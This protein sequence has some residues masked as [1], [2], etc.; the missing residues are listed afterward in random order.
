MSSEETK[1]F[2]RPASGL[3]RE[4]SITNAIFYNMLSSLGLSCVIVFTYVVQFPLLNIAGIPLYSLGII[5]TAVICMIFGLCFIP[6]VAAMPRSG[7]DYIFTSRI[8]HPY[9]GF[10]ETW[11]WIWA[12]FTFVALSTWVPL[13]AIRINLFSGVVLPNATQWLSWAE[14]I[15][16]PS[17]VLIF[18][19]ILTIIL[20]LVC[21]LPTRLYAKTLTI[22]GAI[23]FICLLIVVFLTIGAS[24]SAFEE[25]F[26]AAM[27][28]K[29]QE[30][31]N[32]AIERG[33][34][35][36]GEFDWASFGMLFTFALWALLGFNLSAYL[37]GEL[38][39]D[40]VRN[41]LLAMLGIFG[42]IFS[43]AIYYLPF[44]TTF[45][46]TFIN[47]WAW[48]NNNHPD[49]VPYGIIPNP[50]IITV[51]ARPQLVYLV[52]T[53]GYIIGFL[54]NILL[55]SAYV[56]NSSRIV[57]AWSMDRMIPSKLSEVSKRTHSPIYI[58]VIIL[59]GS[60]VFYLLTMF[61]F[62]PMA[63]L[64]YGILL[65]FPY[66][67][68][69][70]INCIF[71]PYRRPD[72]FELLPARWRKK[73]FGVPWISILGVIWTAIILP[74]YTVTY[75]WPMIREMLG[76]PLHRVWDYAMGESGLILVA[77]VVIAGTVLYLAMRRYNEKVLG[78]NM[79]MLFK[80][81]PPE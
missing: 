74:T 44:H 36:T 17:N 61:G 15:M 33:F 16:V 66:W 9:L 25:N 13:E 62:D 72:L 38:K 80:R 60:F 71:L 7:G 8:L 12:V 40:P 19:I 47:A 58:T 45:G 28:V 6:L 64:W 30:I 42:P 27:G 29:P 26:A 37:A 81:I 52:M 20:A 51:L 4:F 70:G 53:L 69:P 75:F 50:F 48:L 49:L 18:G 2:V 68:F 46:S 11:M 78:I 35:P 1:L 39:G 76:I 31:I 41:V 10:M 56:I 63:T 79:D 67:F 34:Q 73:V 65:M 54:F 14:A 77:G 59:I 23:A 22:G 5:L 24:T 43:N 57:F 32:I 55:S 3:V 21:L